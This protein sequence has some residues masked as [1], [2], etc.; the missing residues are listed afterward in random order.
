[1]ILLYKKVIT[2]ASNFRFSLQQRTKQVLHVNDD[3]LCFTKAHI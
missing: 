3:S 2:Y 1:M